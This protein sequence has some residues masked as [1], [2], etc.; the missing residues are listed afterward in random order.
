MGTG[1][2]KQEADT[3]YNGRP[4]K[5]LQSGT[6]DDVYGFGPDERI[7]FPAVDLD[8]IERRWVVKSG[9][10]KHV[11]LSK[12]EAV[13]FAGQRGLSVTEHGPPR[14][15]QRRQAGRRCGRPKKIRKG[16]FNG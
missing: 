10:V 9:I 16:V 7:M 6:F 12:E 5:S 1:Y 2:Y 11:F 14:D 4:L 15:G 8:I 13:R 3:Y